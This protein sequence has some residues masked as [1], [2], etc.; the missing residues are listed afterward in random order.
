MLTAGLNN[1]YTIYIDRL[2]PQRLVGVASFLDSLLDDK[3]HLDGE[4]VVSPDN[5]NY[6]EVENRVKVR[7]T[8]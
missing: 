2:Q 8:S 3:Q 1:F 4:F 7:A 6:M 5:Q